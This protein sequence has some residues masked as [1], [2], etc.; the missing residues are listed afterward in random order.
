LLHTTTFKPILNSEGITEYA[1]RAS[2][3][4]GGAG[5]HELQSV[6]LRTFFGN[7]IIVNPPTEEVVDLIRQMRKRGHEETGGASINYWGKE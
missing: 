1:G 5:L 3:A 7:N 4:F 2:E 6:L